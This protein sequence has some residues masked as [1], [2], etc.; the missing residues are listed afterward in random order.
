MNGKVERGLAVYYML[1]ISNFIICSEH[2]RESQIRPFIYFD[3][4]ID[5]PTKYLLLTL[6]NNTASS[7]S[8]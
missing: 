6:I 5:T 3:F 2:A 7:S 8:V 4:E 1:I